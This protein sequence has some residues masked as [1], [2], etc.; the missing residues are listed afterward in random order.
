MPV[1]SLGAPWQQPSTGPEM[2][3][4]LE[5]PAAL[6]GKILS[7]SDVITVSF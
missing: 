2:G 3:E 5:D 4:G 1:Y 6:S 7:L